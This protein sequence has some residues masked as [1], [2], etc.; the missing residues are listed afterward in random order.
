MTD[1]T[2]QLVVNLM[3][4]YKLKNCV[5]HYV[6]HLTVFELLFLGYLNSLCKQEYYAIDKENFEVIGCVCSFH[7]LLYNNVLSTKARIFHKKGR[8]PSMKCHLELSGMPLFSFRP[9]VTYKHLCTLR[10]ISG[11]C[12]NR[13]MGSEP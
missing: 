3:N 6:H 8:F 10:L 13:S 5:L 1:G 11:L 12:S 4:M 7:Y 2:E 9:Q